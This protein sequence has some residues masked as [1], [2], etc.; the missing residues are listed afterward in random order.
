MKKIVLIASVL[1][2][3]AAS[4]TFAQKIAYVDTE[5][6]LGKMPE[7]KS[8]QKQLD[9]KAEEWRKEV[10]RKMADVDKLYKKYQ[11]EQVLLPE[12]ERKQRENEIIEKEQDLNEYK[13]EKFGPE[14]DL[15]KQRQMLIKPIQ[16]RVFDAI[17]KLA[18]DQ[19]L[20]MILDK[21]GG[22][23]MLFTNAKYDRSDE[24]LDILGVKLDTD[25][26]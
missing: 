8:A 26:E 3:F 4:N 19:S 20:D 6:I 15:Y 7:Y 22:V 13:K 25:S 16:D 21:A 1:A 9:A 24:V 10:E 17:Q 23:T 11:A 2:I 12:E 18:R 14:G 5:Y